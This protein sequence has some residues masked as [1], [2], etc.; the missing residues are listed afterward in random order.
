MI[1]RLMFMLLLVS[2]FAAMA[3]GAA[4]VGEIGVAIVVG[5]L[6]MVIGILAHI[7]YE[8]G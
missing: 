6:T 7:A 4:Y 5:W 3:I 2:P 8:N 1:E